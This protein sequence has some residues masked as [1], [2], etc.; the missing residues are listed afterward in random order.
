MIFKTPQE[1][2]QEFGKFKGVLH[3]GAHM[4]EERKDYIAAGIEKRVWIEGNPQIASNLTKTCSGPDDTVICAV[5]SEV[6]DESV[7]FNVANNGQSSSILPLKDH[8]DIYRDIIY[9]SQHHTKTASLKTI[10]DDIDKDQELD[11]LNLDIQGVE[12]RAIKGLGNRINQFRA[13]YA[14][15]NTKELYEKCDMMDEMDSYLASHGFEKIGFKMY[16]NDG[17]GDALYVRKS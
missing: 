2:V 4:A 7:C 6:D 9:V 3:V 12:L 8:A 14:E 15:V 10:L 16:F 11:L 17:W 1:I 13:I 5:V